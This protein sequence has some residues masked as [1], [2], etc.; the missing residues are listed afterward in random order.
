MFL[1]LLQV[2]NSG[3]EEKGYKVEMDAFSWIVNCVRLKMKA[4][5]FR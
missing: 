4:I 5:Y 3:T 2:S 1:L